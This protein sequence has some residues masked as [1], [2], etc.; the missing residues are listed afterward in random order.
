M[1]VHQI[2][3]DD[4]NYYHECELSSDGDLTK[5]YKEVKKNGGTMS[6]PDCAHVIKELLVALN[7]LHKQHIAHRDLKPDNILLEKRG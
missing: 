2:L 3:Q 7:F 4:D 1:T 5:H 6:E